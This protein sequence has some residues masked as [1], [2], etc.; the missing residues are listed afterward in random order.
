MQGTPRKIM[1]EQNREDER[2]IIRITKRLEADLSEEQ[3]QPES[4]FSKGCQHTLKSVLRMIDLE[5]GGAMR[6]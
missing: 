2:L 5:R 4:E 1:R 6:E 3:T